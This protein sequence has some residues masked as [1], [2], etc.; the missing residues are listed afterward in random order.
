MFYGLDEILAGYVVFR[1]G[2]LPRIV[3]LLLGVAG[4]C[5]FV[6]GF[7]FFLAPSVHARLVPY[8]LFPC[9][10]GE[11]LYNVW[12]AVFGLNVVKWRAW[13]AGA[14]SRSMAP[15]APVI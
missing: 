5:Y 13:A 2:F 14:P 9:L 3:G 8:I 10:P 12:L 4:A 6:N 1:S 15:A 7:S 11:G